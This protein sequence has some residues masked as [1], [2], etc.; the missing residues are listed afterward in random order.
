M[1]PGFSKNLNV[2]YLIALL[3]EHGIRYVIASPGNTDMEF[4]AGLQYDGSFNLYS[5]V[6]ERG[7]AYMAC[8]MA[9]ESREPV[10]IC[11]TEATAS[12]DYFPGLTEA[13]Y[14]KIP[15]LAITGVHRYNQIGHLQPQ[16]I[17]RSV[18]PNDVFIHKE[19]LPVI[20]DKEDIWES[21]LKINRA[22]LELT[23]HGGGP[24]HIDLP[25]CNDDYDFSTIEL[26][27]VSVIRRYNTGAELPAM[28]DGNIAIFIGSH[29]AFNEETISVIDDFCASHDA[30]VFHDHTSGY[31]GKYGVKAALLSMQ[32]QKYEIYRNIELLIHLGE[33]V[34]DWSTMLKL[35]SVKQV[36]RVSPDGELRDT[37]GKLNS[38]FEMN[39]KNF[40]IHYVIDE[41]KRLYLKRC[42]E[43]KA[44]IE[45]PVNK[46]PF[47]NI[48]AAAMIS[49]RFPQD[50]VVHLGPS[51]TIRAWSVFD[52]PDT[53][54][55][56]CNVGCRGIDGVISACLGASLVHPNRIYFCVLGDLTFFYDMNA[57]GNRHVGRNI[58]ILM[59]NNNG[60]NIFK[61]MTAP[62]HR[63]FG[64]EE[65]NKYIAA[66]GHFGNQSP[67]LVRHY[68]EDLG[69]EYLC[70]YSK[71]E[72]EKSYHR[73]VEPKLTDRAMIFEIFTNDEDERKAFRVV[74][75]ID[76]SAEER[77][78]QFAKQ[79]LGEK[80]TK[81]L[82]K[83]TSQK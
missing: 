24:V 6:D 4:V 34:G 65:T 72:F 76:I 33:A 11:C 47:S 66:G 10:V 30:I 3:K 53:V 44:N 64:D 51:S 71:E 59:I 45:V 7:A 54:T 58:R 16:V 39:E 43:C 80:G 38:V 25:C 49:P 32:T 15:I 74:S 42:E 29:V 37:F 52:F 23:R 61:Q 13:Y 81:I 63:Y 62:A 5:C 8:G 40:F 68:A 48:Y 46:L 17:D 22:L 69:F 56:A 36:W 67:D 19:Q 20:K 1:I 14:R 50:A 2:Q 75:N 77:T 60:G 21:Q 31:S 70:A 28:P 55:S 9:T 73:F 41:D 26:P 57:L 27:E 12:R 78:K 79:L 18:S 83:V 82:K 35:G